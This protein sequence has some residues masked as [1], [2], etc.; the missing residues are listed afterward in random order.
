MQLLAL[1]KES[2]HY[3]ATPPTQTELTLLRQ[4]ENRKKKSMRKKRP[5]QKAKKR[6]LI[7]R[8]KKHVRIKK[9]ESFIIVTHTTDTSNVAR[10]PKPRAFI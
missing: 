2:I 10:K 7:K 4:S 6:F 1:P 5:F 8:K 9:G 3:V